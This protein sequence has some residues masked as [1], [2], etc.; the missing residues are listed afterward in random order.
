V[1]LVDDHSQILDAVSAMLAD[2]FDVVGVATD[3]RQTLDMVR[4]ADPDIVV[5]D[6]EMPGL[7]GF[8]TCHALRQT[9]V[10][11]PVVFLSMHEGDEFVNEAFRCGGRGFVSKARV[12]RDLVEALDQ[13]LC[14][15]LF[16]PSLTSLLPLANGGA[17][18]MQLHCGPE[19]LL[20]GLA[21][22]FELALQRGDATCVIA[23]KEIREGLADRL[24]ARGW[25]VGGPS[26]HRR[27]LDVDA[28]GALNRFMQNGLPE[29]DRLA[30]VA[31]E[32]D[33]FRL[34]EGQGPSP[35][36]MIFGNMAASLS[37]DGNEKAV[38]ALERLWNTLTNGLPFLT[39]CGYDT[40]CFHDRVPNLWGDV[41]GQHWALSH[42]SDL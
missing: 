5:L 8:E 31:A 15:R 6:V 16:V 42:A 13:A 3:G 41:C 18:A 23:T 40:S 33:Q 17:H 19:S 12:S 34:A 4:Q 20:D 14:G 2:D 11:T 26:G 10:P 38:L 25:N 37:H 28:A 1:F 29:V 24:R 9:G 39:L 30:A 27:Y 22:M 7:D 32:L 21:P 35:H 36:L